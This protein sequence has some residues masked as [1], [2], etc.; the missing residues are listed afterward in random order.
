MK[1]MLIALTLGSLFCAPLSHAEDNSAAVKPDRISLFNV[2]LQ[3]PAAPEIGCG[4]KAKPILAALEHDSTITEAW[5]NKAGTVL[6][7]VGAE[8]STPESRVKAVQS[9]LDKRD[10]TAT[11][12]KGTARD[13]ALKDFE[14][15]SGWYRGVEVD[16]LSKQE[17]GIIAARLVRRLQAK[18]SL[19]EEKPRHSKLRSPTYSRGDSPAI[20]TNQNKP[21][22]TSGMMKFS[23]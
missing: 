11:G 10:V 1:K 16:Q 4:S 7:V 22:S 15:R 8:N 19:S 23:K 21:L 2:P 12:L 17:A 6:A 13:T 9:V 5:L 18:V 14:S 20:R 3:C